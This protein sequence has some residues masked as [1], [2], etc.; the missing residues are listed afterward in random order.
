[1]NTA[2][3]KAGFDLALTEVVGDSGHIFVVEPRQMQD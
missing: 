2:K 1:M 3:S